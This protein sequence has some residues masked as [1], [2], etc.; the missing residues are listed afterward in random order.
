M[1]KLTMV[2]VVED[3]KNPFRI[4]FL[5]ITAAKERKRK[6]SETATK[7]ADCTFAKKVASF[8]PAPN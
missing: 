4:T 8:K 7:M 1:R 5:I 2:M 3:E 6:A